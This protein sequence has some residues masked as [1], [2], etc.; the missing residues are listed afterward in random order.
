[1]KYESCPAW[2]AGAAEC[3][4][5]C[6]SAQSDIC[7]KFLAAHNEYAPKTIRPVCPACGQT[8]KKR[9]KA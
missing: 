7:L 1:M 6:P 8:I 2:P 4:V 5:K 9:R 3:P